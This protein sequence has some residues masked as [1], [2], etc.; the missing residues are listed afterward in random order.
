MNANSNYKYNHSNLV[1]FDQ[2]LRKHTSIFLRLNF[3]L[4]FHYWRFRLFLSVSQFI[5]KQIESS[6]FVS[7]VDGLIIIS[8]FWK[9]YQIAALFFGFVNLHA[10][11]GEGSLIFH[12]IFA[13]TSF[14]MFLIL[15]GRLRSGRPFLFQKQ[16]RFMILRR[17]I[18]SLQ[19]G[20][21]IIISR[22]DIVKLTAKL[23]NFFIWGARQFSEL[24]H[25]PLVFLF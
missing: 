15:S 16:E 1:S 14:S 6:V 12:D 11:E 18:L 8:I 20:K 23:V 22:S 19:T 24:F 4:C 17:S 7:F 5:E 21:A 13:A 3:F 9:T 2:I 25:Q 10:P